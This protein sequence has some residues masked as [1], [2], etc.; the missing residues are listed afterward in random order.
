MR[1]KQFIWLVGLL[2]G[3]G[4]QPVWA[5]NNNVWAKGDT[6]LTRAVASGNVAK[7]EVLLAHGANVNARDKTGHTP[8]H[9]ASFDGHQA[10]AAVLIAHGADANAQDNGWTSSRVFIGGV[11]IRPIFCERF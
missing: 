2:A 10:V 5:I 11:I 6:P 3:L 8:L 4:V 1:L 7:V 9:I